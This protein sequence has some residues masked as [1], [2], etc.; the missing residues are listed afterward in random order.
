MFWEGFAPAGP[1][2]GICRPLLGANWANKAGNYYSYCQSI[3]HRCPFSLHAIS[4]NVGL[5]TECQHFTPLPT[6]SRVS[7]CA[8][9]RAKALTASISISIEH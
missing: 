4:E 1:R 9:S 7:L 8:Q 3:S 5:Q 2:R 6:T